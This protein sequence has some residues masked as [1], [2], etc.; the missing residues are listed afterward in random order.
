MSINALN[1]SLTLKYT[2]HQDL[3]I[4]NLAAYE[5]S[6]K[7]SSDTEKKLSIILQ[8]FWQILPMWFQLRYNKRLNAA[9]TTAKKRSRA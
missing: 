7:G 8:S 9:D 6:M 2:F 4:R 5:I 1:I 3:W